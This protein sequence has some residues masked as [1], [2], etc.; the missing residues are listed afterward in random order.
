[1]AV[2]HLSSDLTEAKRRL[3]AEAMARRA[4]CDPASG[5]A[6][7]AHVLAERAPRAGAV[8]SGFWP[9][10]SEIDVRPLLLMLCERGHK[11]ALPVTP[12]R[13]E[14]LRF[15]LWTPGEVL[16]PER[17]GTLRSAGSL[18]TPDFLLVPLLAFDRRGHRLG[19]GAGYYDRTLAALPGAF[20]LG[21]AYAV[22]EV[23]DVPAEP[24]DM[25]LDAVATERGVIFCK[26][27]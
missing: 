11:I 14:A 10:G 20:A 22:Q 16:H 13:G 17:F 23:P 3:R 1:M 27:D 15:R 7:A 2:P 5:R 26:D 4:G 6:L 21:C 25:R 18:V 24:H 12:R 19:Y 8:V 9:I